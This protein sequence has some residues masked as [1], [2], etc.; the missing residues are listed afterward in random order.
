MATTNYYLKGALSDANFKALEKN[1][2]LFIQTYLDRPLQ[3]YLKV[4]MSGSRL[5]IYTKKRIEPKFWDKDAQLAN[6]KKMKTGCIEI[7]N[8]LFDFK[9]Q[10]NELCIALE[11]S[12]KRITRHHLQELLKEVSLP[13]LSHSTFSD[14]MDFFL[15][16][17]RTRSGHPLK[18]GTH[19][20]YRVFLNHLNR[21]CEVNN[22]SPT[23]EQINI[24]FLLGFKYF[25][26]HELNHTDNTVVKNLKVAKTF[27]GFLIKNKKMEP[28]DFSS[29][30]TSET[31]G[32]IYT[33]NVDEIIQI[34]NTDFNNEKL[35]KVRD[36][37]CF[38][39][40]TGQRISDIIKIKWEDIHIN[41][42]GEKMWKIISV[43]GEV[44]VSVPIIKRADSIIEK[45][46]KWPQPLPIIS[47]QKI[48][49]YLKEIGKICGITRKVRKV[50]Y[51]DG[52][53]NIEHVPFY[54]ILSTHVARKSFITN[55]LILDIPERIIRNISKHKSERSFRRYVEISEEFKNSRVREA[56]DF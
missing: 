29:I 33:L 31:E 34:Q 9:Q 56:F 55:S 3:I 45:Y 49:D 19:R 7:N 14:Y 37:F 20:K 1:D 8:W 39:C 12:K 48:N 38:Q 51:Y 4:N 25:S 47:T 28:M 44:R 2:Q 6:C 27:F 52:L 53:I 18:P 36:I 35:N 40:W 26:L 30:K 21:Y 54:E 5:Q 10:V 46:V 13:K 42:N 50:K 17:Y 43:K 23:L 24:E 11:K 15:E 41:S 22:L 32:E 16:N